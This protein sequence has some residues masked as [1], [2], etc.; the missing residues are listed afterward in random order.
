MHWPS[1]SFQFIP[2][3]MREH[4]RAAA[5]IGFTSCPGPSL[6][7]QGR[8]LNRTHARVTT[9]PIPVTGIARTF[10]RNIPSMWL[11]PAHAGAR[12]CF[13][14]TLALEARPIPVMREHVEVSEPVQDR[15]MLIPRV[16]AYGSSRRVPEYPLS[17]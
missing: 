17:C 14:R 11:M 3:R 10:R 16:R 12:P 7:T 9:R 15:V 5:V 1:W 6:R 8:Q 2:A 13:I 4:L